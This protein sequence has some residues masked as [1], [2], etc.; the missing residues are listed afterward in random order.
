[1]A[2]Q[3]PEMQQHPTFGRRRFIQS[4]AVAAAG[5][6]AALALQNKDELR[7]ISRG[8]GNSTDSAPNQEN[9]PLELQP[10]AEAEVARF[11]APEIDLA[12]KR[13]AVG[14]PLDA[15]NSQVVVEHASPTG[16]SSNG[17]KTE[18]KI[19]DVKEGSTIFS[20]LTGYAFRTQAPSV[21]WIM[22]S[23]E[24]GGYSSIA[25]RLSA[26]TSLVELPLFPP[27]ASV[28]G[29]ETIQ[30]G[31]HVELWDPLFIK[32][33]DVINKGD[34]DISMTFAVNNQDGFSYL[35]PDFLHTAS[36]A[37]AIPASS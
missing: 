7:G 33:K 37:I 5:L 27:D 36:G 21:I 25:M 22:N 1:M 3:S 15:S 6:A 9:Q 8:K 17:E 20:P 13:V 24:G 32:N 34:P 31:R 19:S 30:K 14:F 29:V 4:A 12:A 2:Q 16:I 35:A 23:E 10:I 11:R 18:V 26:A 28:I